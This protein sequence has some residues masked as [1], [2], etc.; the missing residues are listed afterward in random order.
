M[1]NKTFE[2]SVQDVTL[3]AESVK[4]ENIKDLI[5]FKTI[6]QQFYDTFHD[7]QLSQDVFTMLLGFETLTIE[8]LH[9]IEVQKKRYNIHGSDSSKLWPNGSEQ[10][11]RSERNSW[12]L[13]RILFEDR[14]KS[15]SDSLDNSEPMSI[16][17]SH[18]QQSDKELIENFYDKNSAI[19]E[20][21]LVID[22]LEQNEMDDME[23][24][25][26]TEDKI[27]FYNNGPN[28][29]E[30]TLHNLKMLD[31]LM[32][33]SGSDQDLLCSEMDPDAPSKT[34]KPLHILDKED[35]TRLM[36]FIYKFLRCG[37]FEKGKEMASTLGHFWLIAALDGWILHHDPNMDEGFNDNEDFQEMEGNPNRDVWKL[38]CWMFCQRKDCTIHEKAIFGVLSGNLKVVIPVC[39]RWC[40][41]LWA[42]FKCS[43]DVMAESELRQNLTSKPLTARAS[44]DLALNKRTSV[45]LPD[46]YWNNLKS[47]SDI[48]REVEALSQNIAI[49]LEE[50][51]H[52]DI[53]KYIILKELDSALE[54][55]NDWI[56]ANEE[57]DNILHPHMLKFFAHVV[58]SFRS[59]GIQHSEKGEQLCNFILES[60]VYHLISNKELGLIALY[61]SY[62]LPQSQIYAYSK[63]LEGI[64]DKEQQKLCLKLAKEAKLDIEEI[65]RT[66]V[67]SIRTKPSE[68]VLKRTLNPKEYLTTELS[69]KITAEDVKKIN[70]LDWLFLF[71]PQYIEALL[72]G[73]SLMRTFVLCGKVDAGQEAFN[74]LPLDILDGVIKTWKRKTGSNE[75]PPELD[76]A[77]KEYLCFKAYFQAYESFESWL[78]FYHNSKPQRPE[79]PKSSRF[80]DKVAFEHLQAQYEAEFSQ[81]KIALMQQAKITSDKIYN[82][83]MFPGGGWMKDIK[84]V[85]NSD[86]STPRSHQLQLLRKQIIPQLT[87][88][89]HSVLHSSNRLQDCL[90]LADTISSENDQLYEEFT[91]SQLQDLLRKFR[92]TAI[93]ALNEGTDEIGYGPAK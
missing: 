82:V 59:L 1:I 38:S 68:S 78:R 48:F 46:E 60:Y 62:L 86:D 30:N 63:L 27:E 18:K 7:Y 66:A 83:F 89:L 26:E 75:L 93:A 33:S 43:V 74:K 6:F 31:N 92:E 65:T 54:V 10:L 24:K 76:N 2:S 21:Q 40:D 55:M 77:T 12:R 17:S 72:Q 19:R 67:E 56:K 42:Y 20:M 9:F 39:P 44:G 53:Q 8:Y 61:V 73:N 87:F 88:I 14:I 58:I 37:R 50:K 49:T 34:C 23:E 16:D 28:Y 3:M 22:W 70:A 13:I 91:K 47:V 64:T 57:R 5:P 85:E 41:K 79:K 52:Q 29:W 35:D 51:C 36:K 84:E 11:I 69:S 32:S 81:W 4:E 90:R 25:G 80:T 71:K 45:D 15:L